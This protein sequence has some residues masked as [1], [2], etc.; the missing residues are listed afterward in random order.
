MTKARVAD[1][2]WANLDFSYHDLPYR[3]RLEYHN[4]AW[5]TGQLI[6]DSNI[7][8][9]EA[10]VVLHYGQ[11]TFE[12]LKAYRRKDGGI[13][14]FRPY[15]NAERI[16]NS[17]ARLMMPEI[18]T[19]TFVQAAIE[20]VQANQAFVPPYSSG[21]TLYLR[22]MLI[23]TSAM[24][25]V[26]PAQDYIFQIFATP[27]GPYFKGGLTPTAFVTST[28]DRA[29]PSGTGQAKVGGNYAASLLPGQEAHAA[30]YSDVV[31]LDPSTHEFIEE[32]GAANFYGIT[33]DGRLLTP[34]SPSI[35]PS[36]TKYSVLTIAAELGLKVEETQ[37]SINDIDQFVEAGAMGTAAVISPVASITHNGVK[38]VFH[39]ETEPGPLTQ[40]IYKR[41]TEIQFGDAPA[42]EADW[43]VDVPLD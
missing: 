42:P 1:F 36:I 2:D 39:S 38:H 10:A 7:V 16:N 32:L 15:R 29:A 33:A 22:P 23:G 6:E 24:V 8:L 26:K 3:Y 5:E 41:L 12:G 18:P 17:A 43:I 27:V 19:E 30:G 35:L 14:L 28:F 11:E 20:L 34:K 25:G 37:I 4:G 31:Y 21:A 40:A 9:S 13:N